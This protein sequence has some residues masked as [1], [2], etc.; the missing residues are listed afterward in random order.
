MPR[1]G[2]IL[3]CNNQ[4]SLKEQSQHNPKPMETPKQVPK[5]PS[6]H[7]PN[8]PNAL[9]EETTP[10]INRPLELLK[11][12]FV[13]E[14]LVYVIVVSPLAVRQGSVPTTLNLGQ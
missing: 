2:F 4:R 9:V 11:A 6:F 12:T 3:P 13:P 7:K 5:R 8:L 1:I 14:K 10:S